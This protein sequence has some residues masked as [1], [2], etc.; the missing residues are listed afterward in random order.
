MTSHQI[1]NNILHMK[2]KNMKITVN[3]KII[4]MN[5]LFIYI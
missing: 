5:S 3:M 2:K 4:E 1:L